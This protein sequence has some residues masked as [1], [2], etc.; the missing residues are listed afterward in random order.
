MG[1]DKHREQEERLLLALEVGGLGYYERNLVTNVVTVDEKWREIM[2]LPEGQPGPDFAAKSLFP[3][4]R[5]RVLALVA[6]A[7]DPKLQKVVGT[8]FRIMRPNGEIRWVSGRGRVVFDN[9]C[10]P[11]KGLKFM[12]VLQDITRRKEIEIALG[13]SQQELEKKVE[14]RT[15][16]LQ[17]ANAE[18]QA[19]SYSLSHDMRNPLRAVVSYT[20]FV[21]QDEESVL[22][23]E[24]RK[25]L[26]QGLAAA[27]RLDRL[28]EDVLAFSRVSHMP[29][30]LEPVN[31]ERLVREIIMQAPGFQSPGAEVVAESPLDIVMGDEASLRQCL[32]NLLEN[33]VKFVPAGEKPRVRIFTRLSGGRVRIWVEDQGIGID[34]ESQKS[35]FGLF[36]R[37]SASK[38][39]GGTGAGLAIAAK[40][41]ERMGG[42]IGVE[43]EPGQGSRFWIELEASGG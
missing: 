25:F 18:L 13:E 9:S 23:A 31:V 5:D 1:Y 22:T 29:M 15:A 39:F 4:D 42:S 26:Q 38:Q 6:G 40:A 16:S 37:G 43:S 24:A 19:F 10:K 30:K 27:L 32:T 21:L 35:I 2:G 14:E 41:A 36:E 34:S 20:E 12:G 28:I 3:E 33:A 17:R 8:D 7:F 11:P